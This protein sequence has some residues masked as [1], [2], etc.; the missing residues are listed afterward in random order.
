[1]D[2]HKYFLV[3]TLEHLWW[4]MLSCES[5]TDRL[6][7]LSVLSLSLSLFLSLSS[8]A[9]L[10]LSLEYCL[11]FFQCLAFMVK[12]LT[13]SKVRAQFS[14]VR[15][16]SDWMGRPCL[17]PPVPAWGTGAASRKT[18]PCL[19]QY[20]SHVGSTGEEGDNPDVWD[21]HLERHTCLLPVTAP[22][23]VLRGHQDRPCT[24]DQLWLKDPRLKE[25]MLGAVVHTRDPRYSGGGGRR[26]TMWG[27][28]G[29]N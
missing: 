24:T 15:S 11:C 8:F 21:S 16:A 17:D 29:Q 18:N 12:P 5:P 20:S 14:K 1:M 19:G 7:L 25:M 22:P 2:R 9:Q 3:V 23:W 10:S 26:I 6:H 27:Q 13:L 28:L 4:F